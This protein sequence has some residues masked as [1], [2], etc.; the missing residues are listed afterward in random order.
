MAAS[1]K[2][3]L[4]G[5]PSGTAHTFAANGYSYTVIIDSDA[6]GAVAEQGEPLSL[7]ALNIDGFEVRDGCLAIRF[8]AKPPTWL[9]GFYDKL[10]VRASNTLPMPKDDAHKLNLVDAELVLEGDD[11][12]T[13]FI[14]LGEHSN[15]RFFAVEFAQ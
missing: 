9:N 12:A 1:P 6:G 7:E 3:G 5:A 14:P 4:L 2:K 13:L 8:T 11:A 15:R 10:D